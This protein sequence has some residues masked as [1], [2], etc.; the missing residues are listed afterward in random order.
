MT[1]ELFQNTQIKSIDFYCEN[2]SESDLIFTVIGLE[3]ELKNGEKSDMIGS[4]KRDPP[5]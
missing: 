4:R 1:K 5:F 3:V 2:Y